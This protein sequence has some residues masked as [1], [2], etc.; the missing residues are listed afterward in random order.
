MSKVK[1]EKDPKKYPKRRR[2]IK[3]ED[4]ENLVQKVYKHK[5]DKFGGWLKMH[6]EDILQVG[7]I[8]LIK[9]K[10]KY[11]PGRGSFLGLAWLRIDTQMNNEVAYLAKHKV[12]TNYLEDFKG[13][14]NRGDD[15]V[16]SWE[17]LFSS[18]TVD[19]E[20]L[21]RMYEEGDDKKLLWGMIEMYPYKKLRA[22]LKE[23]DELHFERVA[24]IKR[25]LI[26]LFEIL[27]PQLR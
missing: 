17:D 6:K 16:L 14:G 26:E 10:E 25:E 1:K 2:D 8:G 7:R 12:T 5:V 15:S 11:T 4:Y 24:R 22:I 9:A 23:S 13:T 19:Y 20:V 3:L 21:L 18:V 27:H